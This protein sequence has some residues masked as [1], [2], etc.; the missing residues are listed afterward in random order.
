MLHFTKDGDSFARFA[1]ELLHANQHVRRLKQV[2]VDI[3]PAICNRIHHHFPWLSNILCVCHLR[4]KDESK[5]V[6]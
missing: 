2:G 4:K 1:L 3:E 6:K 5:L